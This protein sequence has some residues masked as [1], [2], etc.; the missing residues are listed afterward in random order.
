MSISGTSQRRKKDAEI[1]AKRKGHKLLQLLHQHS[2]WTDDHT[3]VKWKALPQLTMQPHAAG[4]EKQ[5]PLKA[6]IHAKHHSTVHALA[7]LKTH[8]TDS[9]TGGEFIPLK[10]FQVPTSPWSRA[11]DNS[12][13]PT[14]QK[15]CACHLS[16]SWHTSVLS[17]EFLFQHNSFPQRKSVPGNTTPAMHW[18]YVC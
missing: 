13:P 12:S 7:T 11:S 18:I 17:S 4:D 3:P 5:Q 10:K 6:Q 2:A 8:V 14:L 16:V 9:W 15:H 1:W